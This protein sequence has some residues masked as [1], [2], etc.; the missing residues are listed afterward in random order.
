MINPTS[1]QNKIIELLHN[2]NMSVFDDYRHWDIFMIRHWVDYDKLNSQTKGRLI[3]V[4][5]Y[6]KE[7]I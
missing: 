7:S 1:K 4:I 6:C 2:N 3:Q 5:D